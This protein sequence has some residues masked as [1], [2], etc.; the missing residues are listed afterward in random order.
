LTNP[1]KDTI[2]EPM[3]KR[4]RRA[5]GQQS[6]GMPCIICG[7]NFDDCP[8]S[9]WDIDVCS[10]AIETYLRL[11]KT[12]ETPAKCLAFFEEAVIDV[13]DISH[14]VRETGFARGFGATTESVMIH[15]LTPS[16]PYLLFGVSMEEFTNTIKEAKNGRGS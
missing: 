8:H 12:K 16:E 13:N 11:P 5:K 9:Y 2:S 15:F 10:K 4:Y 14:A 1:S 3:L 6:K 7:K